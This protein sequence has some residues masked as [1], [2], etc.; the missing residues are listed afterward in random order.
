LEKKE[1]KKFFIRRNFIIAEKF[2]NSNYWEL[3][4]FLENLEEKLMGFFGFNTWILEAS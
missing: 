2:I 3:K 1:F 4:W